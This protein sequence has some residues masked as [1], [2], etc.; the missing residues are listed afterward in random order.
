MTHWHLL[1]RC[2]GRPVRSF[3]S[4]RGQRS[5]SG[6][7]W[8]SRSRTHVGYESWLER[9]NLMLLDAD[10]CVM[11]VVSQPFWLYWRDASRWRRHVP[12]F[13]VRYHGGAVAVVDVRAEDRVEAGDAEVFV[14]TA[15]ACEL[16]GWHF[17]RVGV[18]DAVLAANL[19]WLSGYRHPRN[20][21]EPSASRLASVFTAE[22]ELSQGCRAVGDPIAV[23]PTLF[24]LLWT[25]H[26]I[27][28]L[29]GELLNERTLLRT[30]P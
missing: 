22:R 14:V 7:W 2:S 17:R 11:L 30:R 20:H 27:A 3:P 9:D 6:W 12:D 21:V 8:L 16:V 29:A 4:Y 24:H 5:C 10:P 18:V 15:R 1:L 23:L 26:L 25:G 19:R 28:D 13:L